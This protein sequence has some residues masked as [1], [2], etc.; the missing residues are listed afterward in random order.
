M[1]HFQ[2]PIRYD[3]FRVN[4]EVAYYVSTWSTQN[5]FNTFQVWLGSDRRV[6]F[7]VFLYGDMEWGENAQ[8][9]FNA[10]DFVRSFSLPESLTAD[11]VDIELRSNINEEGVFVFRVDSKSLP[12]LL[13]IVQ[14]AIVLCRSSNLCSRQ[15]F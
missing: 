12:V 10:G 3:V 8:I 15:N 5:V 11:T 13:R 4:H 1:H 6:S 14:P 2:I 9:G 7:V